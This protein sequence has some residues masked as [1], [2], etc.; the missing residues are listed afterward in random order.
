MADL[1]TGIISVEDFVRSNF[2]TS[3]TEKQTVP[4]KP[5]PDLFV[6]RFQNSTSKTETRFHTIQEIEWQILYFGS[7]EAD[8]LTK[9]DGLRRASLNNKIAIPLNDG[10]LRYLRVESFTFS[11]PFKN[12]NDLDTII[13]V[14]S[15][16]LRE[17]RDQE[18]YEKITQVH[19]RYK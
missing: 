7:S 16:T 9:M 1:V 17:A 18:T 15:T 3:L 10:S 2:S 14:L 8:A 5:T 19:S 13:G 12:E 4:K 11:Q 6:I